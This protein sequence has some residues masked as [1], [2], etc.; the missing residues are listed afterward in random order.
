MLG[1]CF[2]QASVLSNC[3]FHCCV[4]IVEDTLEKPYRAHT[5]KA[6]HPFL[7]GYLGLNYFEVKILEFY[8][9]R[10]AVIGEGCRILILMK[11]QISSFGV[12]FSGDQ[13]LEN[14][15]MGLGSFP[16]S[17]SYFGGGSVTWASASTWGVDSVGLGKYKMGDV[18]GCGIDW[19]RDRYF[20]TLNGQKEGKIQS[21]ARTSQG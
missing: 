19:T 3:S 4:L 6:N 16:F 11:L 10:Y 8:E 14:S 9:N 5:V 21:T 17:G 1:I 7:P 13:V 2:S 15:C 12:G 20:F 18:V